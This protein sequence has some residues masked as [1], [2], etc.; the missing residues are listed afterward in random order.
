MFPTGVPRGG[1][2]MFEIKENALYSKEDI[3]AGLGDTMA[4]D[5]S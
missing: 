4:V 5:P 2:T 3:A 1:A